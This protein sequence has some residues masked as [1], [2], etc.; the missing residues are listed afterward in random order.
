MQAVSEL[1]GWDYKTNSCKGIGMFEKCKAF[2][3]AN[4]EQGIFT[5]HEHCLLWIEGF[6]EIREL[7]FNQTH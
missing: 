2:L 4:E 3:R 1:L 6:D 5:L 7:F